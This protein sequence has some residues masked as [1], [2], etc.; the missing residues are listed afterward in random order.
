MKRDLPV[1]VSKEDRFH[2]FDVKL[3]TFQSDI[4]FSLFPLF[5]TMSLIIWMMMIGPEQN[6]W[7]AVRAQVSVRRETKREKKKE[8]KS[9]KNSISGKSCVRHS[10]NQD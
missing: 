8:P 4:E 9:M 5:D 3:S 6:L 7:R 2:G 10:R 1:V